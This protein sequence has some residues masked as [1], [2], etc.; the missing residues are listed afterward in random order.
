MC[1]WRA[2][3]KGVCV[4]VWDGGGDTVGKSCCVSNPSATPSI[5]GRAERLAD[6]PPAASA[7]S[8]DPEE[9]EQERGRERE[10][11]RQQLP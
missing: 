11:G 1:V 6:G 10:S 4:C 8:A 5:L 2:R 9:K 3:I 7:S